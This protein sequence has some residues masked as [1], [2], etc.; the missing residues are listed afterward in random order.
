MG[1]FLWNQQTNGRR[2]TQRWQVLC[3]VSAGFEDIRG[4][5][6]EL[7]L[8]VQKGSLQ[9]CQI[10]PLHDAMPT[11]HQRSIFEP[12]ADGIRKIL[13]ATNI[14]VRLLRLFSTHKY[15]QRHFVWK[16][17]V[18]T[19]WNMANNRLV[20][21]LVNKLFKSEPLP[22]SPTIHAQTSS[23]RSSLRPTLPCA[24]TTRAVFHKYI[25]YEC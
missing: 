13:L 16:R 24:F 7:Q 1:Q 4:I 14:A 25:P 3:L 22:S 10:M 15:R 8:A 6:D 23:G 5:H 21:L 20:V 9:K 18:S 19:E 2:Q 12:C 17:S 11:I